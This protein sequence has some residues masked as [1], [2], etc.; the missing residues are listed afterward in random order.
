MQKSFALSQAGMNIWKAASDAYANE[1]GTVWQKAGAAAL[2]TLE[3]GSFV[4][5]IEAATPMAMAHDGID[6]VPRE[7]TWLLD[8]GE[9][10]VD[11]RTNADLKNYLSN[12]Q[13]GAGINIQVNVTDSGV[14][15]S[16]GN[17]QDQKQFGQMLGNAVRAVIRQ[18]QRQGGLLNK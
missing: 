18:E 11:S 7:G 16:G 5:L 8:K 3:S 4:A 10:V 9:R 6:E 2:A 14:S 17:T 13:N 15:T 1:P 12:Q